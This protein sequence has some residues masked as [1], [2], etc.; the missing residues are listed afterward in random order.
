M[1]YEVAEHQKNT[2]LE[3]AK[4]TEITQNMTKKE[5]Q[6]VINGRIL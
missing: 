6:V 5:Q 1:M 3:E 4:I 2:S